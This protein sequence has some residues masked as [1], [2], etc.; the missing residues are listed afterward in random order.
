MKEFAYTWNISVAASRCF[1]ESIVVFS[2]PYHSYQ[3]DLVFI[4][5]SSME[6]HGNQRVNVHMLRAHTRKYSNLQ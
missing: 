1:E 3:A 4:A 6:G 5:S 2:V